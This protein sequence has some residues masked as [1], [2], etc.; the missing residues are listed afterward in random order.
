MVYKGPIGAANKIELDEDEDYFVNVISVGII[1][2]IDFYVQNLVS[3]GSGKGLKIVYIVLI[4]VG[5][6]LV[7]GLVGG[8]IIYFRKKKNKKTHQLLEDEVTS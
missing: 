4:A 3:D 2:S 7:I 8:G 1:G 6:L 5:G